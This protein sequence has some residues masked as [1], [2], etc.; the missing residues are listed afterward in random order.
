MFVIKLN[1]LDF[2]C[3]YSAGR[4]KLKFGKPNKDQSTKHKVQELND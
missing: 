1:R 2:N 4:L 3:I